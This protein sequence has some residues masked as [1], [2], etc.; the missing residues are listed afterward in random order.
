MATS[1]RLLKLM[2]LQLHSSGSRGM[3]GLV[4]SRRLLLIPQQRWLASG[5]SS[6]SSND[7]IPPQR[8]LAGDTAQS[9]LFHHVEE[10]KELAQLEK[11][12]AALDDAEKQQAAGDSTP[13]TSEDATST[14]E[15]ASS[16][17]TIDWL[18]TRRAMLGETKPDDDHDNTLRRSSK[19][20][21][22]DDQIPAKLHTLLSPKELALIVQT[23][24]GQ[25]I[26]VMA[27]GRHG[28]AG[29]LLVTSEHHRIRQT[30]AE[31][32]VQQMKRRKLQEVGV[33]G[34]ELGIEGSLNDPS[35]TWLCV[36]C[37]SIVV[38]IQTEETRRA[39]NL[40]GLWSGEDGMHRV[41]LN[42][43]DAVDEYVAAHP[44]PEGYNDNT[45][46]AADWQATVKRLQKTRWL[47]PV[48]VKRR[49][50]KRKRRPSRR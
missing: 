8:P 48:R 14:N 2:Q 47:T 18:Q 39:I 26:Q 19:I 27:S 4:R 5:S 42:D 32:V 30:I 7:W 29:I 33:V 10:N 9:N 24:G 23:M 31:M 34:A 37:H 20:Q 28:N 15:E 3:V 43:D 36:D 41:D 6:S 49:K 16:S 45:A 13:P 35:E 11:E 38:H 40:E 46:A 21:D 1:C 17:A 22:L 50:P 25:D 12:L 44:V